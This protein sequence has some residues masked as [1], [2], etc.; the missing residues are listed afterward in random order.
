MLLLL[1]T[2]LS[3]KGISLSKNVEINATEKENYPEK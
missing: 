2:K 1:F 3:D